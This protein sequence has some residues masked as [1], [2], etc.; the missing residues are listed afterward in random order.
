MSAHDVVEVPLGQRAPATRRASFAGPQAITSSTSV[1]PSSHRP[2]HSTETSKSRSNDRMSM[3]L[4]PITATW[5]STE[6]CLA[7][8]T[9]AR[10][11][12]DVDSGSQQA[13]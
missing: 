12:Y 2:T 1:W 8:K 11:T 7:C 5:S 3:L 9:L 4:D 13:V 6:K 10:G